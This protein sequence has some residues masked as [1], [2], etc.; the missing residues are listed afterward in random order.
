[1]RS[2]RDTQKKSEIFFPPLQFK[3]EIEVNAA[4]TVPHFDTKTR[5]RRL[6]MEG[7]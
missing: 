5:F 4:K 6:Y 7:V 1:L 2:F 3:G